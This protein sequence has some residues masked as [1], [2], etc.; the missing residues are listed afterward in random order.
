MTKTIFAYSFIAIV[1]I[2]LFFACEKVEVKGKQVGYVSQNSGTTGNITG[3]DTSNL[4]KPFYGSI[5]LA[6]NPADT[7]TIVNCSSPNTSTYQTMGLTSKGKSCIIA[8][9]S[10]PTAGYYN[11]TTN[12]PGLNQATVT[13]SQNS[14]NYSAQSGT[15]RVIV[16]NGKIKTS[17]TK[18]DCIGSGSSLNVSATIICD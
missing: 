16:D 1:S 17:I 2:S 13:F 9:K 14:V 7:F 11:I 3:N 12:A 8:F 4:N 6:T 5:T 10:A 18:V 15:V